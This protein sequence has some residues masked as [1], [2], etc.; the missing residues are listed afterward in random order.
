M[1]VDLDRSAVVLEGVCD[2]PD[3]H[4]VITAVMRNMMLDLYRDA[5]AGTASSRSAPRGKPAPGPLTVREPHRWDDRWERAHRLTRTLTRITWA[6]A[7]GGMPVSG[8]VEWVERAGIRTTVEPE[9]SRARV[10]VA[11]AAAGL[12]RAPSRLRALPAATARRLG[13]ATSTLTRTARRLARR[14]AVV[15]ALLSG[16][17]LLAVAFALQP[18]D[19]PFPGAPGRPAGPAGPVELDRSYDDTGRQQMPGL[20]HHPVC[21]AYDGRLLVFRPPERPRAAR[22][23][24]FD[25]P[26]LLVPLD[27]DRAAARIDEGIAAGEEFFAPLGARES[28]TSC[29]PWPGDARWGDTTGCRSRMVLDD[30]RTVT[31]NWVLD[32]RGRDASART[33][34]VLVDR[35]LEL[36]ARK[37]ASWVPGADRV[38]C[39]TG[40]MTDRRFTCVVSMT[41]S[42]DHTVPVLVRWPGSIPA[43]A[44]GPDLR[45]EAT[46]HEQPPTGDW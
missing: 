46:T 7:S 29:D 10:M 27:P 1:L 16:P 6:V 2:D 25:D 37:I 31:I 33:R 26:F 40:P 30:G 45:F 36:I 32:R 18:P 13:R 38:A 8:L 28:T 15:L 17:A 43:G 11:A 14:A 24:C 44:D 35:D 34:D 19:T 23:G 41:G 4:R 21:V 12:R 9:R 3:T 20:G 5:T 42:R 39:P 22:A